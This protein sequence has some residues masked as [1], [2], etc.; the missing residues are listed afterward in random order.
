MKPGP[1]LLA[2]LAAMPRRM[3]A[4]FVAL[5]PE[6]HR[7]RPDGQAFAFAEHLWHLADLETEAFQVRLQRLLEEPH[8]FLPDFDGAA[9]ARQRDYLA[10]EPAEG[11]RRF[12]AARVR[13]LDR[14][15]RLKA[16]DW[17]LKGEQEGAGP[18]A[19]SDLPAR[20]AAHDAAHLAEL[21]GLLEALRRP[22]L[23]SLLG[24]APGASGSECA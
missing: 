1:E 16:S 17:A 19:L 22:T 2:G 4:L 13:S 7:V 3:A 10:R 24:A 20:M 18:L 23:I 8:P 21:G 15:G 14:F 12:A 9:V 6:L 11:L 5:E